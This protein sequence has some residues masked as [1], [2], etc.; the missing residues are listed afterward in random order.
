MLRCTE[1]AQAD[2]R[3]LDDALT[4]ATQEFAAGEWPR[5]SA[6]ERGRVLLE[7]ARLLR[8]RHEELALVEAR[9]AGHPIGDARWEAAT[10]AEVF[11]YYAGAANKHFGE[12]V[13]DRSSRASTWCCASRSACAP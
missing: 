10:A 9:G 3:D 12:V 11:E 5:T 4:A 2:E 13:P 6:T 8:E 1:L 7:V